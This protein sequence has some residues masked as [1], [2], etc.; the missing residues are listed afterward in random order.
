MV[1][2]RGVHLMGG[3]SGTRPEESTPIEM[4]RDQSNGILPEGSHRHRGRGE[5]GV[6]GAE[7][8]RRAQS[9]GP[10]KECHP[11]TLHNFDVKKTDTPKPTQSLG[12]PKTAINTVSS[13][14]PSY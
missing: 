9:R 10:R 4:C 5:G 7:K 6:G 11:V 14:C 8:K 1:R 3:I 12:V 2:G 13:C